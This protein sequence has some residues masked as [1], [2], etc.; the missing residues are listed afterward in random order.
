MATPAEWNA[1]L[2]ASV[3]WAE[4]YPV[5]EREVRGLLTRYEE[6]KPG[7]R[8]TTNTL[9][10]TLYPEDEARGYGLVA[11]DRLYKAV[12]HLATQSLAD[13]ASRG[14]PR[15]GKFGIIKPWLWHAPGERNSE[16]APISCCPHCGGVL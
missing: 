14:E 10:R 11:R 16:A 15:K 8:W 3:P 12:L 1:A 9:V 5:V 6:D 7:F 13:C 2:A 4:V